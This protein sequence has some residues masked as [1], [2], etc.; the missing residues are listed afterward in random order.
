M[1]PFDSVYRFVLVAT[2]SWLDDTNKNLGP[3]LPLLL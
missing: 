3:E 2:Y 1:N